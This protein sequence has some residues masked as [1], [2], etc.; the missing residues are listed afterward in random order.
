MGFFTF[1]ELCK[2]YQIAQRITYLSFMIQR[3]IEMIARGYHYY[4]FIFNKTYTQV[5]PSSSYTHRVTE[6]CIG[7]NLSEW[8]RLEIR[9]NAFRRSENARLLLSKNFAAKC[10]LI[11]FLAQE[12]T[13][14]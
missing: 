12:N 7:E 6:V 2:W 10:E 9:L 3:R 1:F 8:S 13:H 5:L 4:K 14:S 11:L